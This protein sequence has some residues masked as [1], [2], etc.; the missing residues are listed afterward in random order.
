MDLTSDM[1]FAHIAF[2]KTIP[3]E[4]KS[5]AWEGLNFLLTYDVYPIADPHATI[6]DLQQCNP[7]LK[8]HG[9]GRYYPTYSTLYLKFDYIG[10]EVKGNNR[11]FAMAILFMV[12]F[13][14]YILEHCP[15]FKIPVG[16]VDCDG[17]IEYTELFAAVSCRVEK[18]V[19]KAGVEILKE[20]FQ[21]IVDQA[22]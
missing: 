1:V 7:Y 15:D 2:L 14:L 3:E 20:F 5:A 6:E 11:L 13:Y 17:W 22:I 18:E 19:G 4:K 9:K 10:K 21:K 16:D 8:N 12:R